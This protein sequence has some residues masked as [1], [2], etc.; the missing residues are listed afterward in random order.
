MY[1]YL[2]DKGIDPARIYTE[3]NATSTFENV[4]LSRELIEQHG[5]NPEVA[6]VT[7]EFHQFR[8]QQ[9]VKKAGLTVSG[10]VT[11]HTPWYLLASY[12]IRDFAG[13]CHM[14]L[15]GT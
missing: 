7:Q 5:L 10:A 14:A 13:I 2:V 11:A 3:E 8:A 1:A 9:F 6:V 15:L 12:W 4:R